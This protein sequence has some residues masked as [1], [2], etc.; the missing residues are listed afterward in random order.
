[1][2]YSLFHTC[3]YFKL[4]NN[5]KYSSY[6]TIKCTMIK[7]ILVTGSVIHF[8]EIYGLILRGIHLLSLRFFSL[9]K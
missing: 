3:L 6:K 2:F 1:M 8:V 9:P 7:L 5:F 4:N